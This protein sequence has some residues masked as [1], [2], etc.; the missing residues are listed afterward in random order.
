MPSRNTITTIPTTRGAR[1]VFAIERLLR[2]VPRRLGR[3]A[4]GWH[5]R[6]RA[7]IDR[8]TLREM[9]QRELNDLGLARGDV[10]RLTSRRGAQSRT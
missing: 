10:D 4:A 3:I 8:E 5:A 2:A 7:A 9:S 1:L 6:R